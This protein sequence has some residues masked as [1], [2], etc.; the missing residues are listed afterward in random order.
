MQHLAKLFK[1]IELTRSQ[2]QSGYALAGIAKQDLSDL[3]QHHYLVT[4]IAWQLA[5]YVKKAGANISVE[6]VLEFA[7]VHDLG[8]LM[9]GDIAMPYALANPK[10]RKL[11]KAFELENQRY[12][13]KFFD[14]EEKHFKNLSKE[15]L[16]AKSDEARIAKMADYLE[17]VH[18]KSYIGRMTSGDVTMSANKMK[19]IGAKMKDR[20]AK[21]VLSKFI[22]FWKKG[23]AKE[24]RE[25]FEDAKK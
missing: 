19:R 2:P 22:D 8:E 9:G 15:I 24:T 14:K 13:A 21:D 25:F 6:K 16:N 1:L 11:A 4:F 17:V 12:L 10:A 5:R 3:A 18:Y 7:L 23:V 20:V